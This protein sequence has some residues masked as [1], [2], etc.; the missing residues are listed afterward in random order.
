MDVINEFNHRMRREDELLKQACRMMDKNDEYGQLYMP[1]REH[2][3]VL[4]QEIARLRDQL[5]LREVYEEKQN[6]KFE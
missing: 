6:R 5:S 2:I 3:R 1:T 4:V